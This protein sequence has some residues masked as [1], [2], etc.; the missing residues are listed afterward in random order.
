MTYERTPITLSPEEMESIKTNL[1]ALDASISKYA[2]N[3]KLIEI[4]RTYK[5]GTRAQ[6]FVELTL[7]YAK[8][9]PQYGSTFFN[10]AKFQQDFTF[11]RC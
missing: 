6:P 8:D 4:R 9:F 11:F 5:I 3:L 7:Q 1:T 10:L 2:V